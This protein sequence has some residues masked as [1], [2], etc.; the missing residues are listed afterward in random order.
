MS[1]YFL[2]LLSSFR[3]PGLFIIIVILVGISLDARKQ[4]FPSGEVIPWVIIG[5]FFWPIGLAGYLLRRR[6]LRRRKKSLEALQASPA[7]QAIPSLGSLQRTLGIVGVAILPLAI[8]ASAFV[9]ATAPEIELGWIIIIAADLFAA[10]TAVIAG[11][12]LVKK[13]S[14]LIYLACVLA[15]FPAYFV[16][17][18]FST[19]PGSL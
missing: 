11:M 12:G 4:K 19:P 6:E 18:A 13:S 14:S 17:Q 16:F 8:A 10:V 7:P 1:Y 2:P 5:I 15:L 3:S 9:A